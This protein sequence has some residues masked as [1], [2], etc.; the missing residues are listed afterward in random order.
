[1]AESSAATKKKASKKK[2]RKNP[3]EILKR[4][5]NSRTILSNFSEAEIRAG[6]NYMIENGLIP[7]DDAKGPLNKMSKPILVKYAPAWAMANLYDY[8]LKHKMEI[9]ASAPKLTDVQEKYLKKFE[10]HSAENIRKCIK[11]QNIEVKNLHGMKKE[12]LVRFA[13][14][15]GKA[16]DIL[17]AVRVLEETQ[18]D[19]RK[20][21]KERKEKELR[22]ERKLKQLEE[23][24]ERMKRKIMESSDSEESSEEE[25][26]IKK[27]KKNK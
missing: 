19:D 26:E 10:N 8:I 25:V 12:E 17:I 9:D 23:E 18:A 6:L 13:A 4:T 5:I 15:H 22:K 27:K 3:D 1:M 24:K 7:K 20:L 2:P 14:L 16:R 21:E 11:N